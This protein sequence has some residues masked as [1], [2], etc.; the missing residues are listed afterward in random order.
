MKR[1]IKGYFIWIANN[2]LLLTNI[3]SIEKVILTKSK[4]YIIASIILSLLWFITGHIIVGM[5][6]VDKIEKVT[7]EPLGVAKEIPFKEKNI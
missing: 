6:C 3:Y 2:A 4:E 5:F 7:L 1:V